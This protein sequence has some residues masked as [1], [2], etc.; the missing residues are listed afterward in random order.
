[1]ERVAVA[2]LSLHHTD[3][4]GLERVKRALAALE[5][6]APKALADRLG[7]SE[8][9]LLSTC[10]RFEFVYARESGSAP[11]RA[12]LREL[13]EALGLAGDPL[14]ERF[15][16]H[17]GR[18]AA[19]HLLRVASSLD[20]LV[21]GEGEILAQVR[22][23]HAEA[24]ALGL[25]GRILGPLFEQALQ[26]G[27]RV[28]THT[29]LAHHPVSVVS[30]GVAF[31]LEQLGERTPARIAVL[32]AGA[33]AA[34]AARALLAAGHAPTFIVNR[35][36]ARAE[37]LAQECGARV[38]TLEE[39]R[40]GTEPLDALVSAT[41]AS[42]PLLDAAALTRLAARSGRLVTVDLAMP[43]DLA[44]V[45]DARIAGIDLETLRTRAD[46][47][48]AKRATAAAAAELLVEEAL[49]Q[50]FRE[51]AVVEV[52]AP[53]ATIVDDTRAAF[54]FELAQLCAGRL[55]HLEARDRLAVE[56]W[57]RATFGRLAHVPFRALK[58]LARNDELP[59][60]EWEGLE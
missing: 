12:D 50:L 37:S 28:R 38:L 17:P 22:A 31:L 41:S 15:F 5:E 57:A 32:G 9:V 49:A 10:N 58:T 54:E 26:L 27:K 30:L 19:R 21:L 51:R 13:A 8:A 11:S 47:N 45:V 53:Y 20:S 24:R 40:A 42:E 34:H 60:G 18:G 4:E 59:H 48:R 1:M 16:L 46:A 7:A 44:P 29:A 43:R 33:T 55:A 2:G 52:S 25:S 36:R 14:G 23:A 6:P 39:L 56:R 35:T 3:V